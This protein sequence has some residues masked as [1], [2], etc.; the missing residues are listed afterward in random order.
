MSNSGK[1]GKNK[2]KTP[3]AVDKVASLPVKTLIHIKY[4]VMKYDEDIDD[5][6]SEFIKVQL[7]ILQALARTCQRF[8]TGNGCGLPIVIG[9]IYD[10]LNHSNKAALLED[11]VKTGFKSDYNSIARLRPSGLT[12]LQF[13]LLTVFQPVEILWYLGKLHYGIPGIEKTESEAIDKTYREEMMST[14]IG[15]LGQLDSEE[16]NNLNDENVNLADMVLV[17]HER[18][19]GKIIKK[20]IK[21]YLGG[22]NTIIVI[23][24]NMLNLSHLL[25]DN[26]R[27]N[28]EI[29]NVI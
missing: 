1:A 16:F 6:N 21:N 26:Y 10:N 2:A 15:G 4:P 8:D 29:I 22:Y 11:T 12:E 20:T 28:I 3:K 5:K 13:Q 27:I 7:N 17:K 25:M 23:T 24:N 19:K 18:E 9:A 14:T